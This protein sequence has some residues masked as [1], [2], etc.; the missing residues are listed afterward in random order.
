MAVFK[1]EFDKPYDEFEI[2][3]ET[4]R[5]YYD[6]ESLKKYEK[7]AEKFSKEAQKKVDL[8][9]MTAK[10][11]KALED[12]QTKAIK[13]TVEIFFGEGSF[14][15]IYEASGKSMLNMTK[16]LEAV[17]DWLNTKVQNVNKKAAEYYTK[18]SS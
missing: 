6:D 7:A 10:Q 4:Y 13:E 5:A 8:E 14:E 11:K 9:N 17:F 18:K 16:V 1:V 15:P 3:G 12:R 2:G